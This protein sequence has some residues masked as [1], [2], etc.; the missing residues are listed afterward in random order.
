MGGWEGL[1]AKRLEYFKGHVEY[2]VQPVA[3]PDQNDSLASENPFQMQHSLLTR[4]FVE[5]SVCG[6]SRSEFI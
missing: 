1:Y 5:L 2:L 4:S 3:F 6:K